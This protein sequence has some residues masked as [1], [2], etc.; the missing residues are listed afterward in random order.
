MM[1]ASSVRND[2]APLMTTPATPADGQ[3]RSGR[4]SPPGALGSAVR[5]LRWDW[6]QQVRNPSAIF[7]TLALPV[8]FLLAFAITSPNTEA[9]AGY[10]VPTMMGLA[11]ASGTLTNLAV[12]LTYLREYGQLKRILVTP[13]PRSAFLAGRIAAAGIVSLLTCAVLGIVGAAAYEVVPEQLWALLLALVII[14][15]AGSAIGVL[16]T[17]IIRSETAAAPVANAIGL[18]VMLASGVFFPLSNAPD[19]FTRVAELLPFTRSVELAV[20]AY[21]GT[22]TSELV[23]Q[24]LLTGGL[25]TLAAIV[26]AVRFF[27]WAP[28]KRR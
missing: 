12:T 11:A 7:F 19:W 18:P 20:A 6:L 28:R 2:T 24:A 1:T 8:L 21:D 13:L 9:A 27:S 14:V 3:A 17:T 25:W 16:T 23:L 5:Q 26:L 15:T 10:Y 22:V 4:P